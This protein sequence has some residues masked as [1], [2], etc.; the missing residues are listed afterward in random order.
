MIELLKE[1]QERIAILEERLNNLVKVGRIVAVNPKKATARVEFEDRDRTVSW[2]I[3]VLHNHTH[4]DKTYWIPR[5]GELVYVL[6]PSLG[7]G[8]G[9]IIGSSY[10]SQDPPPESDG[11]IVKIL[12]EDGTTIQY[13]KG[14][15]KL[16]IHSVGD[17]EITVNNGNG[18]VTI[19]GN[20]YVS[21]NITAG[22]EIAD[23]DGERGTLSA[24]RNIYDVHT[25]DGSPPPDQTI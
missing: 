21:Q 25:H 19:N 10:N 7:E 15:H 4:K 8:L 6:T 5:I 11:N 17:I 9:V 2:E 18:T 14:S 12:F 24:L 23:L 16:Y 13:D 20:L 3:P 1:L 22:K